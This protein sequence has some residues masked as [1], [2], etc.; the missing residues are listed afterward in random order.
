MSR[1]FQ[2]LTGGLLIAACCLPIPAE[3]ATA[4]TIVRSF[5]G[6][7]GPGLAACEAGI[8]HC[9]LPKMDVTVN[10]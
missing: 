4:Q 8:T 9:G 7:R 2:V 10:G 6:D 3:G 1:K 5:D